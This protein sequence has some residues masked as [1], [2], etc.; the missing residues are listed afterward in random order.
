MRTIK[1]RGK[2]IDN[3]EWVYGYMTVTPQSEHHFI[4]SGTMGTWIIVYPETVGQYT[5]PKDKNGKEIYGG[6]IIQT[7]TGSTSVVEWSDIHVTWIIGE[8]F[9]FEMNFARD[10]IIGNI[11]D[12]PELIK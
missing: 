5:G 9:L 6:D 12:N 11:H 3:D 2:R 1:F 8:E 10:E 4:G 7:A